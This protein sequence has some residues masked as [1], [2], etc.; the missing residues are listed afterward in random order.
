TFP[1]PTHHYNQ[2]CY[3][4]LPSEILS[5]PVKLTGLLLPMQF[6]IA[7]PTEDLLDASL[8]GDLQKAEAAIK[9][10]ADVNGKDQRGWTPLINS[11]LFGRLETAKLLIEKN[12]DTDAKDENG[13]T[14]LMSA[15]GSADSKIFVRDLSGESPSI[16]NR[17]SNLKQVKSL[18]CIS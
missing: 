18:Y 7:D 4:F 14:V 17:R 3:D 15:V 9:A 13:N 12:A 16:V 10:G 2:S 5:H 6:L 1:F 8:R 11:S